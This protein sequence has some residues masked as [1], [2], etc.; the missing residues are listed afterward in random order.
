MIERHTATPAAGALPDAHETIVLV[1]HGS[2][3]PRSAQALRRL[4]T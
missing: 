1:G 2:R 4:T 3:D